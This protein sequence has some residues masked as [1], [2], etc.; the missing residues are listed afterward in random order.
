MIKQSILVAAI[1]ALVASSAH[2]ADGVSVVVDFM[3]NVNS[4][5]RSGDTA[6]GYNNTEQGVDGNFGIFIAG[7]KALKDGYSVGFS[8]HTVATTAFGAGVAFGANA[9]PVTNPWDKYF[10][11]A[12]NYAQSSGG[13]ASYGNVNGDNL[14]PFCNDEVYGILGTPYG[15]FKL[16][17]IMNP[18]R[19]M[20]DMATVD[21]TWGDQYGYYQVADVRGNALN[22][23]NSWDNLRVDA[24]WN[25]ASNSNTSNKVKSRGQ[26]FTGVLSYE[27]AP[28]TR[29]GAGLMS[30]DGSFSTK[31]AQPAQDGQHNVAYGLMASTTLNGV[32]LGYTYMTGR[33]TASNSPDDQYKMTDHLVK[34]AYDMGKWSLKGFL[35]HTKTKYNFGT[36]YTVADQSALSGTSFSGLNT[37][38]NTADLW[39]MYSLGNGA[40]PYFRVNVIS[41]DWQA[42]NINW[43]SNIRAT[44]VQAGILIHL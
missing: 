30:S 6:P 15:E 24:Q 17:N 2:A 35:G 11:G 29:L 18:M 14:G 16:G 34:V 36:P 26:V 44:L 4:V 33:Q 3:G 43:S 28:G 38:R 31:I 13:F 8:C 23:S 21:P 19:L 41:K 12:E 32:N 7:N 25:S 22:Y 9:L 5:S 27:V 37:T 10:G 20:Y 42:G 39:A 40:T 1:G